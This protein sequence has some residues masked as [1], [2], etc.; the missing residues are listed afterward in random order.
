MNTATSSSAKTYSR[1]TLKVKKWAYLLF[2]LPLSLPL[3]TYWLGQRTGYWDLAAF[4]APLWYF[5]IIPALDWLIGKD[6]ANP[7]EE[8]EAWLSEERFYRVLTLACLPL[9][10]ALMIWGAWVLVTAPFSWVG[11][12][13]WVISMGL[14][15]GVAAIN[16]GHEL[17][18]KPGRMEQWAG[19]LLLSAVSYGSFKVEHIYG[20]H[21]D[22]ATPRDGSTARLG[23]TIYGF[24]PRAFLHNPVR[25]FQLE[26]E[27]FA[28]RNK[29]WSPLASELIAWYGASALFAAACVAVVALFTSAPWWLGLAYFAAQSVVAISL[30]E[31]IN[32]VEHYGLARQKISSGPLAGRYERVNVTHSWNSNFALTNLLLFQLQRHSD[33]HAH[34]AR[35][36]QALRHF[37]E[38]PQLPAGYATMVVLA[39]IPP[40]WRRIMDPRVAAYRAAQGGSSAA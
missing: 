5:V 22:V 36:Y 19:G 35:R 6:P 29:A 14:V 10:A 40:L 39:A 20:H 24:V 38:S 7:A 34:A 18:H 33:H 11:V 3:V 23:E 30:L 32:Y 37:D 16:T 27:A 21:V 12:A 2:L 9:Y 25:A 28:R 15:G 31:I 1:Y 8:D 26:R 17:I 4:Y 13:G